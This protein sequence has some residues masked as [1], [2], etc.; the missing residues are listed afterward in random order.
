MRWFV[1]QGDQALGPYSSEEL[2][3]FA[4]DGSVTPDSL[5]RRDDLANWIR[6][7]RINGLFAGVL[8]IKPDEIPQAVVHRA[9]SQ[10]AESRV[11]TVEQTSKTWK[12]ITLLGVVLWVAGLMGAASGSLPSSISA[13][14][15]VAP[16]LVL[17]IVGKTCAWWFHG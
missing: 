6:A 9:A 15:A 3:E 4:R 13:I 17:M 7:D 8:T 1:A 14:E 2:K 11:Q 10:P 12:A 16:G 5:I